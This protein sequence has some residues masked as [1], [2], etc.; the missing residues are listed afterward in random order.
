MSLSVSER[1]LVDEL[2]PWLDARGWEFLTSHQ[3]FPNRYEMRMRPKPE[4]PPPLGIHVVDGM[5]G[6]DKVGG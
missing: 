3:Y 6:K 5:K 1:K 4:A 2:I